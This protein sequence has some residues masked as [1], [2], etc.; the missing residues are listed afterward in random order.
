MAVL[1]CDVRFRSEG[2]IGHI[3]LISA[4]SPGFDPLP[5]HTLLAIQSLLAR[6]STLF[7]IVLLVRHI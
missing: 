3:S 2:I 7:R 6:E 4:I 1:R 5:S